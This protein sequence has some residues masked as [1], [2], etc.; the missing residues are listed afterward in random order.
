MKRPFK[1]NVFTGK[2]AIPWKTPKILA[3]SKTWDV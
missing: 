1:M 3:I 2:P